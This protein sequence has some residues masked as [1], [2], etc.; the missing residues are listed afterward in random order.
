M[1]DL[2]PLTP[3]I[4]F[5]AHYKLHLWDYLKPRK[6]LRQSSMARANSCILTLQIQAL[7]LLALLFNYVV[8]PYIP[9]TPCN[10]QLQVF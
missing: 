3:A 7:I 6:Y 5:Q 9:P 4:S 1:L 2:T 10:L 8:S